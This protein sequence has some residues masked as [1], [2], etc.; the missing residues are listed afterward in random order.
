MRVAMNFGAK[1][2]IEIPGPVALALQ[3][4]FARQILLP[5]RVRGMGHFLIDGRHFLCG[6]LLEGVRERDTWRAYD[7]AILTTWREGAEA[8][9]ESDLI[10]LL[11]EHLGW[12]DR[13][14]HLNISVKR[15]LNA[16]DGRLCPDAAT[17][18]LT[19]PL[20]P[21]LFRISA[22][23]ADDRDAEIVQ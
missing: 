1:F 17:Q 12:A 6:L 7:D 11:S 14:V 19:G 21:C 4:T 9:I 5:K 16:S 8:M 3:R 18:A 2:V 10:D 23:A 22:P 15:R 13:E 20:D